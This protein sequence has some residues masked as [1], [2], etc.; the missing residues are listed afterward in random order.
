[1]T[2]GANVAVTQAAAKSNA[3][4]QRT[5]F[6][7]VVDAA[8]A[9]LTLVAAE[10]T[11]RAAQAGVTRAETVARTI[12]AQVNAELRPGADQLR[13][14]AELAAAKTQL[15]Q[16]EQAVAVSKATLAQ[17]AGTDAINRETAQGAMMH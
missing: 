2:R 15:V 14:D 17:F 9:Y 1:M 16:A 13:A 3:A 11:V 5:K 6:E 4:I 8:D 10:A 12:G 7:V